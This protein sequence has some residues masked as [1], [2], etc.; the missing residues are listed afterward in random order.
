MMPTPTGAGRA[1]A[2]LALCL[3]C[4]YL[5][6]A[7]ARIDSID[8]QM[9]LEVAA[10][11]LREGRPTPAY[12]DY[13]RLVSVNRHLRPGPGL[14]RDGAA[15][16]RVSY[17]GLGHSLLGLP[18]LGLVR[19][20]HGGHVAA[21]IAFS[22]LNPFIGAACVFVY[23]LLLCE[24]GFGVRLACAAGLC[25]GLGSP[26]WP[27]SLTTM[28]GPQVALYLLLLCLALVRRGRPPPEPTPGQPP[29][30]GPLCLGACAFGAL[31]LTRETDAA[32]ASP[33]LV[34]LALAQP[35][36]PS[37]SPPASRLRGALRIALCLAPFLGLYVG[38]NL[39]RYG[40]PL[41]FAGRIQVVRD[42]G[43]PVWGDP[44]AALLGLT[45]APEKGLLWFAPLTVA[46][47]AGLQALWQ[48]HRALGTGVLLCAVLTLL[49]LSPL[50]AWRGDWAYGPRYLHGVAPLLHLGLPAALFMAW[51][52]RGGRRLLLLLLCAFALTVQLAGVA[53]PTYRH[54]LRHGM[55]LH[56]LYG[57][58]PPP[59]D[60]PPQW[61][62]HLR[63]APAVF[64]HTRAW[65]DEADVLGRAPIRLNP[66]LDLAAAPMS[67]NEVQREGPAWA[68]RYATFDTL[69]FFWVYY[70]LASG[71]HL[72][73]PLRALALLLLLAAAA[74]LRGALRR[75]PISAGGAGPGP[76][77]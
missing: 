4:V 46:G 24:L 29:D 39:W 8:G 26:L 6:S 31:L 7:P 49:I 27:S 45:L 70:D 73:L 23:T 17:Y 33:L 74:F 3:L 75:G 37:G 65:L 38:Y 1:A 62:S 43:M 60:V 41:S 69:P 11:L 72:R 34:A 48:R 36:Q 44:G 14:D 25:L 21:E 53:I 30:H 28:E 15:P 56:C 40:S 18:V 35:A 66:A 77:A 51:A 61:L 22:L 76:C 10:A 16:V 9:R 63:Q 47:L 58:R 12:T 64:A 59:P 68:E 52:R 20:L 67:P 2:R 32:A 19:L 42:Q 13:L 5:A 57:V 54:F 50:S 55:D 71:G